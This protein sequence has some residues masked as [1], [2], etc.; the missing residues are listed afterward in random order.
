METVEDLE[1]FLEETAADGA[2]GQ[3]LARG[4]AWSLFRQ[5]GV[6][7][8]DAPPLGD[9]I[10]TDLA[11]YG[12]S[13]LRAALSLRERAGSTDTTRRAFERAG[14]AFE[15]LTT[16]NDPDSSETGFYRVLA[17]G[18]YHLAS[19]SAIAYSLLRPLDKRRRPHQHRRPDEDRHAPICWRIP[20]TGK[21][22]ACCEAQEWAGATRG[23]RPEAQRA[24]HVRRAQPRTCRPCE[25]I[26]R[27][28]SLWER[29]SALAASD[30]QRACCAR[31]LVSRRYDLHARRCQGDAAP[32]TL[33]ALARGSRN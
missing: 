31:P 19:Y 8:E 3:L 1:S 4:A 9:G 10:E 24:S 16:N 28:A 18:S 27:P 12:L 30:C 20:P 15:A 23:A 6:L 21:G 11:E 5:D 13:L 33:I 22:P 32:I 29:P 2:R 14:R 25:G 7:P 26:G 17:A